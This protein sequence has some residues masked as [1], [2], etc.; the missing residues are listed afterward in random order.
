MTIRPPCTVVVA[1][2]GPSIDLF[3]PH[4]DRA[5]LVVGVN[6]VDRHLAPDHLIC[7]HEPA[8]FKGNRA[9]F[10]AG[11]RARHAWLTK[12]NAWEMRVVKHA[13]TYQSTRPGSPA[14]VDTPVLC[15]AHTTVVPAVHLAYRLGA[16]RIGIAG[17]DLHGHPV[18]SRPK[19]VDGIDWALGS[20][21][22]ALAERGVELVHLSPRSMVRSLQH[23]P[24]QEWLDAA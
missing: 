20:L 19:I 12:P 15:T 6:D 21:R 4:R 22:I 3:V 24:V 9:G 1:A 17:C 5:D 7:V 11:T 8:S 2:L 13:I 23:R 18:L 16:T 10:I 14:K